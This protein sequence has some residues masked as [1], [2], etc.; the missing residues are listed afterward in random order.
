MLPVL[1]F[2]LRMAV[3]LGTSACFCYN[4]A[5]QRG[6]EPGAWA[7]M[8][9]FLGPFG[10]LLIFLAEPRTLRFTIAALIV[11]GGV[12]FAVLTPRR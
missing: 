8:G 10:I 3:V 5:R 9:A 1:V 7:A 2:F 12:A 6:L 4:L 11:L